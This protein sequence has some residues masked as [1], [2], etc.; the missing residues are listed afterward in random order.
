MLKHLS[1]CSY[2]SS[3]TAGAQLF[4]TFSCLCSGS[5]FWLSQAGFWALLPPTGEQLSLGFNM[6]RGMVQSHPHYLRGDPWI[7]LIMDSNSCQEG[8]ILSPRCDQKSH[9]VMSK[10]ISE[11]SGGLLEASK[12]YFQF[13]GPGRPYAGY[14]CLRRFQTF[15]GFR[16]SPRCELKVFLVASRRSLKPSAWIPLSMRFSIHGEIWEQN[17]RTYQGLTVHFW[18]LSVMAKLL[19]CK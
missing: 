7:W 6:E 19:Y 15:R 2:T 12:R 10:R 18:S 14:L 1:P 17:L 13:Q 5:G 4:A 3:Q 9:V 8:L 11:C 16:T